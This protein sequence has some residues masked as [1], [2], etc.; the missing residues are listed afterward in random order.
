[1]V[2]ISAS[3]IPCVILNYWEVVGSL[4]GGVLWEEVR[5]FGA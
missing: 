5:L 2:W 3:K 1:M 4:K